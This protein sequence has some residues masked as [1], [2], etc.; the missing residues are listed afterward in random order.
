MRRHKRKM[1]KLKGNYTLLIGIGMIGYFNYIGTD[2]EK[3]IY[4]L[5]GLAIYY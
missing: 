1:I 5:I 3:I 4:R 2:V